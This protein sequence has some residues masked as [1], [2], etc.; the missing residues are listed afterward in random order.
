MNELQ[1]L[2]DAWW[3]ATTFDE[4][5][6]R[7]LKATPIADLMNKTRW[8]WPIS[9]SIHFVGLALLIGI[10]A[11]L[12]VR[13]MGFMKGVSIEALHRLVPWAIAGFVLNL[14]TGLMFLAGTPEQYLGNV[15]WWFKVLF[16]LIA[17]A[18]M[19]AFELTQRSKAFTMAPFAGTPWTLKTIGAVSL[20]SWVMVLYWGRM[21]PFAGGSF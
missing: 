1:H 3:A 12:D 13:L 9:E 16:L 8:A 6:I 19:M 4:S 20:V 5:L 18:N 15:S 2:I 7:Y 10:V 14:I 21:L 17:G 11:P